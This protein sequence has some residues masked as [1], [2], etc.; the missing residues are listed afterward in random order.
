MASSAVNRMR[1]LRPQRVYEQI[2]DQIKSLI[3]SEDLQPGDRLPAERDL[4]QR[5]GVSRPSVR[6]AMIALDAAG[7]IDVRIGEGTFVNHPAR[8]NPAF[9]LNYEFDPGPGPLEQFQARRLIEPDLAFR[10]AVSATEQEIK[11][12][13]SIVDE[14]A[15][16]CPNLGDFDDRLAYDFHISLARS[17][18]NGVLSSVVEQ[19]WDLRRSEMWL[20]LRR[21][22]VNAESR[23]KALEQRQAILDALKCRDSRGARSAMIDLLERAGRQYFG[24]DEDAG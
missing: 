9:P 10:A 15:R 4:A 6:E 23:W 8:P 13:S 2:A 20:H 3:R 5:L 21:R 18:R 14:M 19:L 1:V 24:D 7:Y 17:A 22:V 16:V 11:V 12:L